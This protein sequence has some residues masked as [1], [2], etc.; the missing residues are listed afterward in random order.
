VLGLLGVRKGKKD[1]PL[2]LTGQLK[3]ETD[4][5]HFLGVSAYQTISPGAKGCLHAKKGP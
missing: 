2:T 5:A 1:M 3:E 4:I